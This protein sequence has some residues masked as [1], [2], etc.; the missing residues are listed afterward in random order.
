MPAAW[1]LLGAVRLTMIMQSLQ[2]VRDLPSQLLFLARTPITPAEDGD[3]MARFTGYVTIA[4]LIADDQ[5]AVVYQNT[6]LAYESTAIPNIK[7]G[8]T[9]TQAMLNKLLAL[10]QGNAMPAE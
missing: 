10:R 2:D 7:H 3:I 8:T 6:K 1:D 4:D 5:K 9:L